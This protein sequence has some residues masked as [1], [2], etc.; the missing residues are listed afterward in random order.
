LSRR[1]VD[2]AFVLRF[3]AMANFY[4][5][6]VAAIKAKESPVREATDNA[7]SNNPIADLAGSNRLECLPVL[8]FFVLTWV[9]FR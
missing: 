5:A 8:G 6:V 4:G 2:Q 3:F 7:A 9:I 1:N